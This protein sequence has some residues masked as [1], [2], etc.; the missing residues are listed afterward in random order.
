MSLETIVKA[1]KTEKR[2]Q[3]ALDSFK[4]DPSSNLAAGLTQLEG[5]EEYFRTLNINPDQFASLH[6]NEQR[7]LGEEAHN[8]IK[9]TLIGHVQNN[10]NSAVNYFTGDEGRL[11]IVGILSNFK[12]I[13]YSGVR[14]DAYEAH[15]KLHEAVMALANPSEGFSKLIQEINEKSELTEDRTFSVFGKALQ[16]LASRN[17]EIAKQVLAGRIRYMQSNLYETFGSAT[18]ARDYLKSLYDH[19]EN[20]E[21]KQVAYVLGRAITDAEG[22][23]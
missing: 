2:V 13:K 3:H 7:A 5:T 18:Y 10:Y 19:S 20:K 1:G 14:E 6:Q 22:R 8:A 15:K 21:K 23:E 4:Q 9:N 17:D 11:G 12:P 16:M